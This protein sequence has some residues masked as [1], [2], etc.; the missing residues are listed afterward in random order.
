MKKLPRPSEQQLRGMYSQMST[1]KVGEFFGVGH[2]TVRKW[3]KQHGIEIRSK[4]EAAKIYAAGSSVELTCEH[5]GNPFTA[6]R[7]EFKRSPRRYCSH[8][9]A[10]VSGNREKA[11]LRILRAGGDPTLHK[12]C[13]VCKRLLPHAQ[14]TTCRTRWDGLGTRC[15]E[16]A[17]NAH[18]IRRQEIERDPSKLENLRERQYQNKR[19]L[20]AQHAIQT[21]HDELASRIKEE[22]QIPLPKG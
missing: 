14:F 16:C 11:I 8:S 13:A 4:A 7:G 12:I 18:E 5:C 21:L 1:I 10:R 17:A 19:N 9:C 15:F 20:A 2:G 6:L 3:L 22:S